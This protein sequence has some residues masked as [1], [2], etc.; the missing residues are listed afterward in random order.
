MFE[1]R[2][3]G[4]MPGSDSSAESAASKKEKIQKNPAL[5]NELVKG[6]LIDQDHAEAQAKLRAESGEIGP[7]GFTSDASK[8]EAEEKAKE[9]AMDPW[10]EFDNPI[11]HGEDEKAA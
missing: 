10:A 3:R 9:A 4:E 7:E 8:K 5:R 2:P 11:K 1:G 6:E